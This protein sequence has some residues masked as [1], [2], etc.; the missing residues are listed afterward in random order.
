MRSGWND[1]RSEHWKRVLDFSVG[2]FTRNFGQVLP[3]HHAR[4]LISGHH[5]K[6]RSRL[7]NRTEPSSKRKS[8]RTRGRQRTPELACLLVIPGIERDGSPNPSEPSPKDVACLD[9]GQLNRPQIE[10]LG[11]EA[12]EHEIR[13]CFQVD[14]RRIES[15]L[16]ISEETDHSRK[17]TRHLRPPILDHD[18]MLYRNHRTV[19][20]PNKHQPVRQYGN[21]VTPPI[22]ELLISALAEAVTGENLERAA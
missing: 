10:L 3:E 12:A 16:P 18:P 11:V 1:L 14:V 21:A 19:G 8:L 5:G 17:A 20:L 22:A 7:V 13:T 4:M 9:E 6:D 2:F 15:Q